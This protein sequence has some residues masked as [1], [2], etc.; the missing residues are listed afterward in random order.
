M[1]SRKKPLGSCP[2]LI[3]NIKLAP[4]NERNLKMVA[5]LKLGRVVGIITLNIKN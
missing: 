2:S 4:M 3:F 1:Y 5:Q